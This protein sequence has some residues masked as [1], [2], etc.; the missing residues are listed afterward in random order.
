MVYKNFPE[1][2]HELI[3]YSPTTKLNEL[4]LIACSRG[5][6]EV[7]CQLLKEGADINTK[8]EWVCAQ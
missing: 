3:M 4:L 5:S 1:I 7:V 8:D 2:L 6:T